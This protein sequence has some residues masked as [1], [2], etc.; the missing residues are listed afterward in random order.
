MR[1]VWAMCVCLCAALPARAQQTYITGTDALGLIEFSELSLND[2]VEGGCWTEGERTKTKIRLMFQQKGLQVI[3]YKAAFYGYDVVLSE[4]TALGVRTKA[5]I[6]AVNAEFR[7]V[8]RS[9]SNI[10]TTFYNDSYTAVGMVELFSSNT[11]LTGAGDLDD[12]LD[13]FFDRAV[14]E[15]LAKRYFA[16]GSDSVIAFRTDNP[17]T[18]R[19]P[20]PF[21]DY[22]TFADIENGSQ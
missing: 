5:G 4:L 11:L 17:S 3:D 2:M 20:M 7:V 10:G 12:E 13:R 21:S 15:F 9:F 14:S 18:G 16:R 1:T 8:T 22:E 6:C 19:P